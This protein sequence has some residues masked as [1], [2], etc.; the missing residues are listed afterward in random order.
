M[1]IFHT[2]II[3]EAYNP[4]TYVQEFFW[5]IVSGSK[6]LFEIEILKPIV[7]SNF[8]FDREAESIILIKKKITYVVAVWKSESGMTKTNNQI[9]ELGRR[10]DYHATEWST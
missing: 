8:S 7:Y 1:C 4:S 10:K 3:K 5:L 2:I 9:I 6:K